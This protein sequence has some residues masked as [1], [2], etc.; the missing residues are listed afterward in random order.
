VTVLGELVAGFGVALQ[1]LNLLLAGG[2]VALG[3]VVGMLP[4]IGPINAIAILI[5]ITFAAGLPAESV[6]IFLVGIYYGSQYGNSISTILI[7]VPGTASAVVT[8]V[9]GYA[10]TRKGESERALAVAAVASFV[11]GTISVAGLVFFAPA[12][13]HLAVRFGPAEYFALM[14]FALTALSSLGGKDLARGLVALG[15]GLFVAA[16]GIDP[17]SAVPRF[18]FGQLAL[19]DGI[20]FVVVTIGLFA[21]SEVLLALE[22]TDVVGRQRKKLKRV[23]LS[24]ADLTRTGW[25]M[26]RGSVVGFVVGVLPGAGGT[27]AAFLGYAV[28]EKVSH[29]DG[30]FGQGD[31]RGVAAPESANNAAAN[32]SM[33]PLLTLGIPGSG[34]TAVLL[35]ALT[36]LDV[37]PG[38]QL[39]EERPEVFWGLVASMYIGNLLLLVLNL[40]LVGVF[41]RLLRLPRWILMPGVAVLS[42]TAVYALNQSVFDLGLMVAFGVVGYVFRKASIPLA[43]AILGVVLGPLMEKNLRRSLALS[44]GD[45][46]VLFSSPIAVTFWALAAGLILIPPFVSF[47][48]ER[49]PP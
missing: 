25:A 38:P 2:G 22:V 11:G 6:L 7:N 39:V 18:T 20:D 8:A 16:I 10:L 23:W 36:A 15:F 28:E 41:A 40:P 9:D 46:G 49:R 27:V 24:I 17:Q 26:V 45:W 44:G 4:G 43:P 13:A 19:L 34:T 37:T 42:V 29:R 47:L 1:P 14:L 32:G 33:I 31:I 21:V 12:L 35:G 3:T 30:S 5:P 48:R